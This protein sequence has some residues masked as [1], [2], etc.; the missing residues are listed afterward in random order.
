M[1]EILKKYIKN[2]QDPHYNLTLAKHYDSIGQTAA[3]IS[4]YIRTA[5]RCTN[6]LLQYKCLLNAAR[7]FASQGCRNNSVKGLY[8]NAIAIRP[9]RPEAYYLLSS[10][11]HEQ[12]LYNDA[13]MIACL[14]ERIDDIDDIDVDYPGKYGILFQKAI[15]AWW[16]GL[17]DQSIEILEDLQKNYTM[18][19]EF[20]TL[21]TN[22]LRRSIAFRKKKDDVSDFSINDQKNTIWVV[23]D[24]YTKP[25]SVREFALKQSFDEGGIGRGYIGRRTENQ[26][27]FK[28]LKEKFEE[29]IGKKITKW[30]DHGMNGKFQVAWSGEPL[31][32]HCDDQKWGGMLYLTP[33]APYQCG[34]TLYA[35]KQNR[36]RTFN[37]DGWDVAWKDIPGDPHLDGTSFEPV[38][39]VGNVYN[40]LV[41]FDASCIHS[42]SQYFGTVKE[43]ARLWQMFFFDTE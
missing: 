17:C 43:N 38:D 28:G 16:C 8:Q 36:A 9:E 3:A 22:H 33:D 26:Y 13:Y 11:L 37:D 40:R 32:Y 25:D 10:F 24:F 14:G 4:F 35:H 30:E 2:P 12:G 23:D 39:V 21:V 41:I 6:T 29:I 18:S 31:V 27:L 5:E 1:N 34:T 19:P 42:A 20:K 15:S 7:C